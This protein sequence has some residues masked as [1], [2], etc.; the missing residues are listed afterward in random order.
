[1]S[2]YK[3]AFVILHYRN[4][5]ETLRCVASIEDRFDVED[6]LIV[7]VDN[8]SNNGTGELLQQK[9]ANKGNIHIIL[10]QQNLGFAGGNNVGFRYAKTQGSEFICMT[11]SDTY[12]IN[13]CFGQ[14][15]IRDYETFGFYVLGPNVIDSKKTQ[16]NPMGTHVLTYSEMGKI[17]LS[18]RIQII[19]NLL[20]GD[21]LVSCIQKIRHKENTATNA[22]DRECYYENVK[23]HGC[24]LVFSPDYVAEYDG[25]N[26][27]TFLYMEEDL[28]YYE[29]MQKNHLMLYSPNVKIFH[30]GA[31]SSQK[32]TTRKRKMF[33]LRHHLNSAKAIR[34]YM[35]RVENKGNS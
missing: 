31:A 30:V 14:S 8:G 18:L 25:I 9:Y 4:I 29:M 20:R 1:M 24:C 2:K 11:N 19:L 5:E 27:C 3:F 21:A 33:V 10:N 28:L 32:Q 35:R 6:Y 7:V 13:D 22:Y 17:V 16:S 23:L 12:L 15:I 26:E 34:N